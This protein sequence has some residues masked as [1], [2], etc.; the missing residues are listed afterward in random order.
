MAT[1]I[2]PRRDTPYRAALY[3]RASSDPKKRGRSIRDQF[4]VGEVECDDHSWAIVDYYEDRDRSASRAAKQE[5]EDFNRLVSDIKAGLVDIVVYAERSRA[6]RRLDVSLELR[7][8]CEDTNVLLC[9]DG[10]IYNMHVPADRKEFT[11]DAVQSEEEAESIIGRSQRTARLNAQRGAPHSYAPFGY[12]RRYDP[13]D[14][15]LLGQFPHP[16]Q[17]VDVV[18]MFE[19]VA[20]GESISSVVSTLQKH[21]PR[22][23]LTSLRVILKNRSYLG[24]RMYKGQE[25]PNCQ[26]EPITDDPDWPELFEQVQHILKDSSRKTMRENRLVHLL[27]GLAWC[28]PCLK[29]GKRLPESVLRVSRRQGAAR[30]RC[31]T[32]SGHVMILKEV[33]DAYVEASVIEWLSSPAA[34]AALGPKQDVS[35]IR[36]LQNR[37]VSMKEQLETARSM[38]GELDDDGRPRLSIASLATTERLLLPQVERDEIEL[39]RLLTPQ[40]ALLGRLAGVPVKELHRTWGQLKLSEQRR[41]LRSVVN[42]ELRPA[43]SHGERRFRSERVGLT[44]RGAPGFVSPSD[45]SG[46]GRD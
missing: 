20:S 23:S 46:V 24:V 9:Y 16:T 33:L 13:E 2:L 17:A 25:M 8:L 18:E 26:W 12:T 7:T 30:Y 28:A 15:H 22:A 6:S 5:R 27:S 38:A 4:A 39:S 40:D 34:T 1:R 43:S 31:P 42:I 10:R 44:F 3:G 37:I 11:R 32:A 35:Q 14:G 21:R 29:A 41:V 45:R 36:K 19:R